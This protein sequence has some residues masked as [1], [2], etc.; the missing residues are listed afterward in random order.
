M[1][2]PRNIPS[3]LVRQFQAGVAKGD[4]SIGR[5]FLDQFRLYANFYEVAVSNGF[6]YTPTF[7][8]ICQILP[9]NSTQSKLR[10]FVV[11]SFPTI[12][13][14]T[15]EIPG[16]PLV[17]AG[18]VTRQIVEL[19]TAT[20][21]TGS[22]VW[23]SEIRPIDEVHGERTTIRIV[24]VNASVSD[25]WDNNLELWVRT[26]STIEYV[27][28]A[29]PA[30]TTVV[31]AGIATYTW[32]QHHHC[33]WYLKNVETFTV[34][35][36]SKS[37]ETN[38]NFYWPPVLQTLG[39]FWQ[40]IEGRACQNANSAICEEGYTAEETDYPIKYLT[41]V[42]VKEAYNGECRVAI[43]QSFETS[44]SGLTIDSMIPE[45]IEYDGIIQDFR[46]R[47]TLHAE[48]SISETVT[49]HPT[50][51]SSSRS[52]TFA[53]TNYTDW[54]ATIARTFT[55]PYKG[56]YIKQVKTYYKPA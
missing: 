44:V 26:T 1:P 52:S 29:V 12:T 55:Q 10:L 56:G 35:D 39:T 3:V 24:T 18:T 7:G 4:V 28:G 6:A 8:E 23:Q 40:M 15:T 48:V 45:A 47:P 25:E 38:E 50:I 17:C 49:S 19:A 53:A 32:Y 13:T 41:A 46:L 21:D 30:A 36:A 20:I 34:A 43:S 9:S 54:P 33:K 2:E 37:Y 27:A 51:L 11:D 31:A 16:M 22:D 5:A 42:E 14:P